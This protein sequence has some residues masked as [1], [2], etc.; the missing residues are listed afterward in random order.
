[1]L[2][3]TLISLFSNKS[4]HR[5]KPFSVVSNATPTLPIRIVQTPVDLL[6]L[7]LVHVKEILVLL[8]LLTTTSIAGVMDAVIMSDPNA[9]AKHRDTRIL[10]P[11]KTR[12]V[13]AI[14]PVL[15]SDGVGQY[16]R[17]TK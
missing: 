5:I 1:M 4:S 16:H 7:A 8:L 11:W 3:P 10:Q 14:M 9:R 15:C 6:V 13:E 2:P 17:Q 12:W